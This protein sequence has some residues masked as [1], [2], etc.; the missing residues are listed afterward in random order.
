MASNEMMELLALDQEE[1]R[2]AD[3]LLELSKS[4]PAAQDAEALRAC[5]LRVVGSRFGIETVSQLRKVLLRVHPDQGGDT[6]LAMTWLKPIQSCLEYLRN[7]DHHNVYDFVLA[8]PTFRKL[9]SFPDTPRWHLECEVQRQEAAALDALDA[10]AAASATEE[11]SAAPPAAVAPAAVASAPVAPAPMTPD[12]VRLP[13][14]LSRPPK[15]KA[16]LKRKVMVC[17]KPPGDFSDSEDEDDDEFM[18]S[19]SAKTVAPKIHATKSKGSKDAPVPIA[20]SMDGFVTEYYKRLV[21]YPQKPR[22]GLK[23][24]EV[25]KKETAKDYSTALRS[26]FNLAT[27][28][29]YRLDFNTELPFY[30][31]DYERMYSKGSDALGRAKES[32]HVTA[33]LRLVSKL[34]PEYR[35]LSPRPTTAE[36]FVGV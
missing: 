6:N 12:R 27:H 28:P 25:Y 30:E 22:K 5:M 20:Y 15:G 29:N 1:T 16:P 9:G 18:P 31:G 14:T 8:R 24:G 7:P 32:S 26:V 34:F 11:A 36:L 23:E 19:K 10:A 2:Y 21:K 33:A 3:E 35:E 13:S 4:D 17:T